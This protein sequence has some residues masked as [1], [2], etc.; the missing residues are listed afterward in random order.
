[1]A[2]AFGF[3]CSPDDLILHGKS[4]SQ[5]FWGQAF[6]EQRS[7]GSIQVGTRNTLTGW[8]SLLNAFV[9]TKIIRH[10]TLTC[11]LMVAHSHAFST[12]AAQDEPLQ[13][14]RSFPRWRKAFRS[15]CLTIHD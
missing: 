11:S 2:Q 8:L 7:N 15:I 3:I 10:N 12:L 13:E 6:H 1:M 5:S 4:E 14:R 9:L